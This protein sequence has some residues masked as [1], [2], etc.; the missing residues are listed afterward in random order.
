[1]V[2]TVSEGGRLLT[3]VLSN[4][5]T[6]Q[7]YTTPIKNGHSTFIRVVDKN[8]QEVA[9]KLK[10]VKSEIINSEALQAYF[11][12]L[13]KF[14]K[15]S[16]VLKDVYSSNKSVDHKEHISI[17]AKPNYG[18]D[19]MEDK[20]KIMDQQTV[21]TTK[22]GT[23]A[24]RNY[25]HVCVAADPGRRLPSSYPRFSD[26]TLTGK[27]PNFKYNL[28]PYY[29]GIVDRMDRNDYIRVIPNYAFNRGELISS[30]ADDK[31]MI[32]A[33]GFNWKN[34]LLKAVKEQFIT[35]MTCK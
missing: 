2:T 28:D 6:W 25:G 29:S 19:A 11:P 30:Y 22:V 32:K 14:E 33:H 12:K 20:R 34:D 17:Y 9:H 3:K 7:S 10:E 24:N 21:I 18:V 1:M 23:I 8:G 35:P 13:H 4:G 16:S 26:G 31:L 15:K 27:Y 5:T